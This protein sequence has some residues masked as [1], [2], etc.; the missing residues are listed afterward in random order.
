MLGTA[1]HEVHRLLQG[2]WA[3]VALVNF[4]KCYWKH[5]TKCLA[6]TIKKWTKK[7]RRLDHP[8]GMY[9]V[10]KHG[11]GGGDT[12]SEVSVSVPRAWPRAASSL[13]SPGL[14][15]WF[16]SCTWKLLLTRTGRTAQHWRRRSS[17]GG[18]AASQGL[19]GLEGGQMQAAPD[20]SG[21]VDIFLASGEED[22][23][24]RDENWG[25]VCRGECRTPWGTEGTITSHGGDSPPS[26]SLL[27]RILFPF[28]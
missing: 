21:T 18:A 19:R 2:P 6:G 25:G 28:L 16:R 15:A 8:V 23:K 22:G 26:G 11:Q 4:R 24:V 9:F 3:S 17:H 5:K 14:A 7:Y 12:D 10:L 1:N 13:L 27:N 20:L